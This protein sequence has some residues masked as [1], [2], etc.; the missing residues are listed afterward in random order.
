MAAQLT[1]AE[2]AQAD[3]ELASVDQALT[4]LVAQ[5]PT[6]YP[7]WD[8]AERIRCLISSLRAQ[9]SSSFVHALLAVAIQRL[10]DKGTGNG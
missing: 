5:W 8:R 4:Q 6:I 3:Q 7:E 9:V 2:L 1:P 10:S